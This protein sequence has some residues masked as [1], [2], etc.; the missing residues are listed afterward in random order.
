MRVGSYAFVETHG[1]VMVCTADISTPMN[2]VSYNSVRPSTMRCRGTQCVRLR[3][4]SCQ[5]A[6][7]FFVQQVIAHAASV[8]LSAESDPRSH[9]VLPPNYA[10]IGRGAAD[11]LAL[12]LLKRLNWCRSV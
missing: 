9:A 5:I 10:L 12:K 1:F 11:A 8:H 2:T 6:F 3:P 4:L 7:E